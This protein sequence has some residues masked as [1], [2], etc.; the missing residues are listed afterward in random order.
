MLTMEHILTKSIVA[1]KVKDYYDLFD[2]ILSE[3]NY[4]PISKN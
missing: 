3:L 1:D 4:N 2:G